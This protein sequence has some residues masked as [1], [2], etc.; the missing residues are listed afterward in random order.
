MNEGNYADSRLIEIADEL[1]LDTDE[2]ESCLDDE[3]HRDQIEASTSE[4]QDTGI[5][6]T[7]GF[8]INGR[9]VDWD[10]YEEL[11]AEIDAELE[12]QQ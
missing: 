11:S 5:S 10:G 6:G 2:F 7:P 3:T 4:A 12:E 8:Q 9:V 1:G